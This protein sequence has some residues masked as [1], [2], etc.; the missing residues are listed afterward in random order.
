M[1]LRPTDFSACEAFFAQNLGDLTRGVSSALDGVYLQEVNGQAVERIVLLLDLTGAECYRWPLLLLE[2]IQR[3]R[4]EVASRP[5]ATD[6]TAA[7]I[8]E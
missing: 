5:G 6:S 7:S 1:T 2:R 3:R 4:E 8:G